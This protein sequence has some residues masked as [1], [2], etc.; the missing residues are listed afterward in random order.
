MRPRLQSPPQPRRRARRTAAPRRGP[1]PAGWPGSAGASGHGTPPAA[2][3][4]PDPGRP[5]VPRRSPSSRRGPTRPARRRRP[6]SRS[7][8]DRWRSISTL[9]VWASPCN[10]RRGP[11]QGQGHELRGGPVQDAVVGAGQCR[12]D[13][14][15]RADQRWEVG[16]VRRQRGVQVPEHRP[17]VRPGDRRR[18]RARPTT[19]TTRRPRRRRGARGRPTEPPR[20]P[21]TSTGTARPPPHARARDEGARAA[22]SRG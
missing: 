19:T 21:G 16:V 9:P 4:R 20:P 10:G 12:G 18:H 1:R 7:T 8:A 17:E 6:R 14:R 22:P 5:G 13:V 3:G 15:Q 2:S 11:A